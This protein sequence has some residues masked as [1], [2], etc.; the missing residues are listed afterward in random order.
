MLQREMEMKE[1][2][3][4]TSISPERWSS[5]R[6]YTLWKSS[7][8][9]KAGGEIALHLEPEAVMKDYSDLTWKPWLTSCIRAYYNTGK[10]W[11][12][13]DCMGSDILLALEYFGI[14]TSSPDTFV[15]ESPEVL[16][17]IKA[18]STYFTHRS[19]IADWVASEYRGRPGDKRI[20]VT[21]PNP[22]ENNPSETL[23]QVQGT[24]A[25]VLGAEKDKRT[26]AVS[27]LLPSSPVIHYLF[28][29]N[30]STNLHSKETPIRMRRDLSDYV[31]RLFAPLS[32]T[33]SFDVER[34]KITKS[35]GIISSE[36]RGVLRLRVSEDDRVNRAK[37][38]M[39][40]SRKISEKSKSAKCETGRNS[41]H[42]I[43]DATDSLEGARPRSPHV[44]EQ[45]SKLRKTNDGS[46][47]SIESELARMTGFGSVDSVHKVHRNGD[48]KQ[49][50]LGKR[51]AKPSTGEVH[52]DEQRHPHRSTPPP[53]GQ[54]I[55]PDDA[56]KQT[57]HDVI[58]SARAEKQTLSDLAL[59]K[60]IDNSAP[61]G[62]INTAF[63]DL[64]SVTSALS[65][66]YMDESTVGSL[67]SRFLV[68]TARRRAIQ[69]S[70]Q[71][72][73]KNTPQ[74]TG[75]ADWSPPQYESAFE[76]SSK[77]QNGPRPD[78]A[79]RS[80]RSSP[81]RAVDPKPEKKDTKAPQCSF[82]EGFFANMCDP[83]KGYERSPSPV[84]NVTMTAE[85]A[86]NTGGS[87]SMLLS[88]AGRS[89]LLVHEL[90]RTHVTQEDESPDF[91]FFER[92][93][94]VMQSASMEGQ[95]A[96]EW[97]QSQFSIDQPFDRAANT[98]DS[99]LP[100][101]DSS[102]SMADAAKSIGQSLSNQF[103]EFVRLA[104][105][106]KSGEKAESSQK[107]VTGAEF[108]SVSRSSP[109]RSMDRERG[110]Q[111]NE[112]DAPVALDSTPTRWA[113]STTP[114][115]SPHEERH[116]PASTRTSPSSSAYGS[117]ERRPEPASR[118]TRSGTFDGNRN[119]PDSDIIALKNRRSEVHT[120]KIT[121]GGAA[122]LMPFGPKHEKIQLPPRE[123]R[124]ARVSEPK[125]G[126]AR[127]KNSASNYADDILTRGSAPIR[128][129]TSLSKAKVKVD[130]FVFGP[131]IPVQ[132][133]SSSTLSSRPDTRLSWGDKEQFL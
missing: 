95:A 2:A 34:V 22:D 4:A 64:Q 128:T 32:A 61:I 98:K 74:W 49:A 126:I 101:T 85:N 17:R 89:P 8:H 117:E 121:A 96:K 110:C 5:S 83:A 39:K 63:G 77:T 51:Q 78:S 59:C 40:N 53:E 36:L 69:T 103:D 99:N 52:H 26:T 19:A 104:L 81:K 111:R 6:L 130:S 106:G 76:P 21:S 25:A 43:L 94:E 93:G 57:I 33:V 108:A 66:P 7:P 102:G 60:Q 109:D 23:M 10:I 18:W 127:K 20:W 86:S 82:W 75:G 16:G 45:V 56:Q 100:A 133:R 70:D 112:L 48:I 15:F 71:E 124:R 105:D 87:T 113:N 62:Y 119:S 107:Q 11:I 42:K 131:S 41:P 67:S 84:N 118:S 80:V 73:L 14:L 37:A 79:F 35:N 3:K 129:K 92:A 90:P 68:Q 115:A 120:A 125:A 47:G 91:D 65:D 122:R 27:Q 28:F 72:E 123:P 46:Y 30:Q 38:L 1:S 29:D 114:R 58:Q 44:Q 24:T 116:R 50:Q 88:R 9:R 31:R 12:P 132:K 54:R 13:D 97:L 55:K